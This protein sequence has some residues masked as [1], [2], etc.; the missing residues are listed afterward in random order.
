VSL[1][2]RTL[3]QQLLE[4]TS[5]DGLALVL[6]YGYPAN[7]LFNPRGR[8]DGS[9]SCYRGHR[10][11]RDPLQ[12]PGHQDITSH[13][14]LDDLR[15][16]A[17]AADWAEIGWWPL[18]EFLVRAGIDEVMHEHGVG[19]EADLNADTVIERQEIKRLLDPDGMGSDLKMLVQARGA[20][21]DAAREILGLR[22]ADCGLKVE[23]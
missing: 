16:A 15:L 12:D 5:S 17:V 7:R 20:M 6:D 21:I 10:L 22:I 1:Q 9:L 14:N 23:G 18:A 2:W 11:S 3:H 19:E 8:A 4:G 13:V